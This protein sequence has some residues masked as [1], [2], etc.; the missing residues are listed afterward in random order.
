[1]ID[2]LGLLVSRLAVGLSYASHGAQKAFGWFEGPGPEGAA[3]FMESLGLRPGE[4]YATLASFGEIGSG[5]A[6]AL[7]LGG[8]IGPAVVLSGMVVAQTTVHAK[9]GFYASKGGVELGVLYSAAVLA[10][11]STGYGSLSLDRAFGLDRKLR[12]PAFTA[13]AIAAGVAAGYAVLG[14]RDNSPPSGTLAT[15]TIKGEHNGQPS[16]PKPASAAT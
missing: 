1:M 3:G 11:A 16:D 9:N 13:L 12:H 15:P 10:Y 2:D 14:K 5:L 6:I 4:Q 7:G 8:P